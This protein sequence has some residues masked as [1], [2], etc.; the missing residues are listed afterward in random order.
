[1]IGKTI[2]HYKVLEKIGAGGM[3][4]VYKA[5]D[6]KLDRTVALKFLPQHLSLNEEEKKRFIH[7]AK[8]AAVLDHPNICTVHEIGETDEGQLF[9]AMSYYKGK[10]LKEKIEGRPLPLVE[11]IN[12]AIQVAEGLDKAHKKDIVHR[13]I[14]SANIMITDEGAVKILDFGLAKLRGVTKLT[15][16]GT[17]LGT[18]AYMSPEQT[19]GENVDHRTDIWSLGILLYEM[20]I[21]QLP[22]KGEY[23]QSIM[24]A[25]LNEDPEPVTALR[26]GIPLDLERLINKSLSKNSS[27]RF[28]SCAD[29]IV[30]LKK[31]KRQAETSGGIKRVHESQ[32]EKTK[33]RMKKVILPGA[34]LLAFVLAFS[35]RQ[36]LMTPEKV[37]K[38]DSIAV[39]PME[40]LS[41]SPEQEYFTDGMTDE[42]ITTLSKIRSLRIIS[43]QSVMRY[44]KTTK[45]LPEIAR[46]LNVDA[47]VQ[48]TVLRSKGQVRITVQLIDGR[49]DEHLW[50][51]SYIKNLENVLAIQG[52]VARSIA[53]EIE[54]NLS[55]AEEKDIVKLQRIDDAA[56]DYFLQG[57]F[58]FS[59]WNRQGAE[60][61]VQ[62]FQKAIEADPDNARC[63]VW[64]ADSYG[65]LEWY[66]GIQPEE[67]SPE[68]M[69]LLNKAFELDKNLPELHLSLA[70]WKFYRDWDWEGAEKEFR[71]AFELNPNLV[72]NNEYAWFLAAMNQ[73]EEAVTEAKRTQRIDPYA[74]YTNQT[75]GWMYFFA[76]QYDLAKAQFNKM[77]ELEI[78]PRGVYHLLAMVSAQLGAYDDVVKFR[79][80]YMILSGAPAK[81]IAVLDQAYKRSGPAGYW[82]WYLSKRKDKMSRAVCYTHLGEKNQ[83]LEM[84]E[85][86]YEEHNSILVQ[87]ILCNPVF[88]PLRSE[89]RFKDIVRKMKLLMGKEKDVN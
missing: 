18:V 64:L 22:F 24:Y 62:L 13:D 79:K 5:E 37:S 48:G 31:I 80:K 19:S 71:Q 83:A 8:A 63:L 55:T 81:E 66:G 1:M 53:R 17:T 82:K 29:L 34:L 49:N 35:I 42:L 77:I 33:F 4:V 3:G 50:A 45:T 20:I 60:K 12:I 46:E 57:R 43:R 73:T 69:T 27:E 39:L 56:I 41:R 88:D 25:I 30:D 76:R 51:D 85:D 10:T 59:K 52:E 67:S 7:E 87:M 9:I 65:A 72:G 84:L 23:E 86:A 16:E 40:N 26:T 6:T 61:A 2:S 47:V 74:Y 21:G 54:I 75:L 89:P 70:T 15:K 32:K 14:K 38:I 28:P 11:A 78:D 44:K 58:H 36:I 68:I